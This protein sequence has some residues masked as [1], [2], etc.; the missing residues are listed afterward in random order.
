MGELSSG[1]INQDLIGKTVTLHSPYFSNLPPRV[2]GVV[3][4]VETSDVPHLVVVQE[5]EAGTMEL[6]DL[7]LYEDREIED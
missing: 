3:T 2:S 5:K 6:V 4:Y 1:D 7:Y